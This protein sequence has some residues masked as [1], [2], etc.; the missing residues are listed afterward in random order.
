MQKSQKIGGEI[1]IADL[2]AEDGT[3]HTEMTDDIKHKGFEKSHFKNLLKNAGFTDIEVKTAFSISRDEKL[4][5]VFL[6]YGK[7]V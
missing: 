2:E 4:F 7:K 5:P 6:A 3:F 1:A